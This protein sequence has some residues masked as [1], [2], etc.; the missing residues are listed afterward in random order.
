MKYNNK[1]SYRDQ[2]I[3]EVETVVKTTKKIVKEQPSEGLLSR[4]FKKI[5]SKG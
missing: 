2:H 5:A 4:L 3:V 1:R